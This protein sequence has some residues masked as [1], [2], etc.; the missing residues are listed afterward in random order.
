MHQSSSRHLVPWMAAALV[1]LIAGCADKAP[2]PVPPQ[3]TTP[4]AIPVN[5]SHLLVPIRAELAELERL[6]NA[7]V[8]T[9]LK[10][11]DTT[12]A[13]CIPAQRI[14]MC[15]KHKQP[16]KGDACK[17]VPCAIG[18]QKGKISPD[19][20]C[21]LVGEIARGPILLTGAGDTL[22]LSMP[23]SA[24]V[25]AKDVGHVIKSETATAAAEVRADIKLGVGPD[26]QPTAK[27][28]IDYDW[29]KKP[30]IE[31]LGARI[32]FAGKA[33]PELHKIIDKLEAGLPA[34]L[35]GLHARA[36][37]EAVWEKAFT[38]VELNHKNPQV[39]LRISPE[40]LGYGGYRVEGGTLIL[41]LALKARTETFVGDRPADPAPGPLPPP[42]TETGA[43][44]FRFYLPVIADY[45]ELVPVLAKA[46]GK[47]SAKGIMVPEIGRVDAKFGTPTIYTTDGGRLAIGL[48]I[49]ASTRRLPLATRGMVWL[50]GQPTNTANSQKIIVRDLK[51][52][53]KAED[54]EGN[55][56]LAVAQAP[57]VRAEIEK[58]VGHDF[59]GD[60]AKLKGKVDRAL[61]EKQIGD[62]RLAARIEDVRHGS[63][64]PV[65]Q[66]L[67]LPVE[68]I[69]T[70][71]LDYAPRVRASRG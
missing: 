51:L 49:E 60:F 47:L 22:R 44:G 18:F 50:T 68:A 15:L 6:L 55:L 67:F 46:L 27:V 69:G 71:A 34:K 43:P 48:P 57:A 40:Q 13:A 56:L 4:A 30:G 54:I 2:T 59:S 62:F 11:I 36:K 23:I 53:G 20:S 42:A 26:W 21:R 9:V 41:A 24:E 35:A 1:L 65:G 5:S 14:T 39:W 58:A 66:G 70:A 8:P 52:A 17:A 29:T 32:T 61:K 64:V 63:I 28:D 25:S 38:S 12:E 7:D 31:L 19:I 3:V 37:L 10:R 45:G 33:D 16:C